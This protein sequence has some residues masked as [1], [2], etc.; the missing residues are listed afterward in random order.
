MLCGD[1]GEALE[2]RPR[3]FTG[4]PCSSNSGYIQMWAVSSI[5]IDATQRQEDC[6]EF[7]AY[8][9]YTVS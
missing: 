4:C 5:A 6:S 7:K 8:L 3:V 2:N 9:G 1:K